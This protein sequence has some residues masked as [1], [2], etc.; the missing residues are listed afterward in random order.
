MT[1]KKNYKNMRRVKW[2]SHKEGFEK[3]RRQAIEEVKKILDKHYD[4]NKHTID[5][6]GC[7]CFLSEELEKLEEKNERSVRKFI[8]YD[9]A[10]LERLEEKGK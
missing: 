1:D 8:M 10:K 2:L 4:R 6:N 5:W 3:G 7:I 9:R